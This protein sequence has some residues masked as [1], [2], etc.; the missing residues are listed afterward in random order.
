M[1]N[2]SRQ[3]FPASAAI[4]I[5]MATLF[6]ARYSIAPYP[7]EAPFEGGMPLAALLARFS[8][9]W[10]WIAAVCAAFIVLWT[11]L[12]VVQLTVKYAPAASRNYLPMQLF[13][14]GAA[15]IIVSGEALAALAAA[16]LLALACRQF[17]FSLHK[18]YRFSEVFHAGFYMGFIP[19][20][21]APVALSA[22][23]VVIA[24]L[25][26]YRRSLREA[27]VCF[28]GFVLPIP[29][30]GFIHWAAGASGGFIYSELWRCA[31]ELTMQQVAA[32]Y[33]AIAVASLLGILAV[34]GI[35]RV[36]DYK[37]SIR[38]TQYKFMQHISFVLL[39]VAV[40]AAVPGTSTTLAALVAVPCAMCAPYA[41]HGKMATVAS[42][43]YCLI[44]AAVS[45]LDLLPVL[46][47]HVP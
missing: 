45:A 23:A 46:G 6:A 24:A 41:F 21:Y 36:S 10:P 37:K 39:F 1:F 40:S 7:V 9:A 12:V 15:G 28:A 38:K 4:C 26:I 5:L 30:A 42:V 47:V 16:L 34:I 29:A 35:V 33:S 25:S 44:V 11:L 27:V 18:E 20:L 19:L 3:S 32:P 22:L 2:A 17:V 8:V 43:M 13:L 31:A 14:V